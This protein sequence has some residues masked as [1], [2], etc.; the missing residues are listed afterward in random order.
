MA[1]I[2][3][4]CFSADIL[5]ILSMNSFLFYDLIAANKINF[6]IS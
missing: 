3:S 4:R 6:I 2:K 1:D 5:K